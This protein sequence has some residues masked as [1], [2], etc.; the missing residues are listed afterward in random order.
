[1][2]GGGTLLLGQ[3]ARGRGFQEIERQAPCD[4][5]SVRVHR[6]A[7]QCGTVD[8]VLPHGVLVLLDEIR[9]R[10]QGLGDIRGPQGHDS[11]QGSVGARRRA[12]GVQAVGE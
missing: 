1:M 8:A 6:G 11:G 10:R 2:A 3:V 5:Q 4:A 12:E 7:D 9:S